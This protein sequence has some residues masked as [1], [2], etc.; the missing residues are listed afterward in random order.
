MADLRV[1]QPWT[2]PASQETPLPKADSEVSR[3]A[4]VTL[5]NPRYT[6]DH[7]CLTAV[8]KSVKTAAEQVAAIRIGVLR[9]DHAASYRELWPLF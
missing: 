2:D 4:E 3:I 6:R 7:S 1:V 5:F 8:V 9:D